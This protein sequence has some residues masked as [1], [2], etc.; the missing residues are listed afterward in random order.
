MNRRKFAALT[1]AAVVM[2]TA[3]SAVT[4]VARDESPSPARH[5]TETVIRVLGRED[6]EPNALVFSTFRFDAEKSFPHQGERVRLVDRD[7][8]DGAPHSLT[9]VRRSELPET[10][11]EVFGCEACNEA[12]DAHFAA[13]PPDPRIGLGDGLNEPGDSMLIFEGQSIGAKVSAPPG[14]VLRFLCAFHPWMQ[15]R[16]IVG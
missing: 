3:I 2:L 13:G 9:V 10:I 1:I 15:G 7:K 4:A 6:F 16:L 12:L 8:V 11:D 14:S 5:Q